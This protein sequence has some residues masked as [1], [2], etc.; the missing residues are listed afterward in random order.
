ME[1]R[2][3]I[4][5]VELNGSEKVP[6]S[7]YVILIT[8]V[9]GLFWGLFLLKDKIALYGRSAIAGRFNS[10]LPNRVFLYCYEDGERSFFWG[11]NFFFCS[12]EFIRLD[13]YS[14]L[15]PNIDQYTSDRAVFVGMPNDQEMDGAECK[16]AAAIIV[17]LYPKWLP[18]LVPCFCFVFFVRGTRQRSNLITQMVD[19]L[20][21]VPTLSK[22]RLTV[23]NIWLK[24]CGYCRHMI[25]AANG[26]AGNDQSTSRIPTRTSP[27]SS[28]WS[29]RLTFQSDRSK[30][31]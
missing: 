5:R 11:E 17:V 4:T 2:P 26:S 19:W 3:S 20:P 28:T 1:N 15:L 23:K 31:W 29:K 27:L 25:P 8:A 14:S 24:L 22:C 7:R 9:Y 21:L 13:I 16:I 30:P 6:R 18:V 10:C 12:S